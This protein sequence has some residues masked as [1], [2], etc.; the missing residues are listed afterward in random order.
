MI[1]MNS[2]YLEDKR[3][4]SLFEVVLKNGREVTKRYLAADDYINWLAGCVKIERKASFKEIDLMKIPKEAV[5]LAVSDNESDFKAMFYLPEE[6]S[7]SK[8]FGEPLT[9]YQPPRI[10]YYSNEIVRDSVRSE[11]RIFAVKEQKKEDINLDTKL[12]IYPLG[13]VH[14]DGGVCTGNVRCNV[15]KIE[16][17]LDYFEEFFM[18]ERAGHFYQEDY[19]TLKVSYGKMMEKLS[20]QDHFPTEWLVKATVKN[21]ADLWKMGVN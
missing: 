1:E 5:K 14:K 13:H 18:A 21:V 15:K 4:N 20:E 11:L 12:Y 7:G 8:V 17:C 3:G 6:K 19:T 10:I 9:F 2:K 16:D